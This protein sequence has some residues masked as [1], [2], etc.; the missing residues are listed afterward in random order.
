MKI[1]IKILVFTSQICKFDSWL[2]RQ[3]DFALDLLEGEEDDTE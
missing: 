1:V 2:A 3:C